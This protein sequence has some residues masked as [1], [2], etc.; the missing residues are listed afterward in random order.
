M[1]DGSEIE[2]MIYLMKEVQYAPPSKSYYKAIEEAYRKLDLCSQINIILK[3]ALE[4]SL[5]RGTHR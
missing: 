2:G 1:D 4:R 5:R 3:P